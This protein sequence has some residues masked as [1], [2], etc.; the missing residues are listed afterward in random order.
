MSTDDFLIWRANAT[1]AMGLAKQ[2]AAFMDLWE[3]PMSALDLPDALAGL[4]SAITDPRWAAIKIR[5]DRLSLVLEHVAALRAERTRQQSTKPWGPR[6]ALCEAWNRKMLELG[7]IDQENFDRR[8]K[9]LT[10]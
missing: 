10:S 2:D 7:A 6:P 9:G 1:S 3:E 4:K 5:A 8:Q